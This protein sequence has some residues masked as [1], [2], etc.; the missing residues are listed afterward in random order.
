MLHGLMNN[1][2]AQNVDTCAREEVSDE[3]RWLRA[4]DDKREEGLHHRWRVRVDCSL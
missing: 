3:S 4:N 1:T 2:R